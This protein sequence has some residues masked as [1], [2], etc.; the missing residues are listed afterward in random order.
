[1]IDDINGDEAEDIDVIDMGD[2]LVVWSVGFEVERDRLYYRH[3]NRSGD[4]ADNRD[5]GFEAFVPLSAELARDGE[6]RVVF[7]GRFFSENADIP[8]GN[9][10][11]AAGEGMLYCTVAE[12][13]P[14]LCEDAKKTFVSANVFGG[15]L[16]RA[17]LTENGLLITTETGTGFAGTSHLLVIDTRTGRQRTLLPAFLGDFAAT[18]ANAGYT[19]TQVDGSQRVTFSSTMLG[20]VDVWTAEALR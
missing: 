3:G 2:P 7:A 13:G 16:R 20:A 8:P 11:P 1:M 12:S 6:N 9:P 18:D 14:T 17:T 4:I 19:S 15:E 10:V 5:E